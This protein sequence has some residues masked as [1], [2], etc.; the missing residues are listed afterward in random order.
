MENPF[1]YY[2]IVTGED[3]ADRKAEL[4]ELSLAV[5]SQA[6]VFLVSPR[7]YGKSSLLTALLTRFDRDSVMTVYFDVSK[8]TSLRAL[9]EKFASETIKA[10]ETGLDKVA[11]TVKDF[12]PRLRP[13]ITIEQDGTP[14]LK[15]DVAHGES[16]LLENAE[17]ILDAPEVFAKKRRKPFLVVLDEFQ[18]VL[19]FNGLDLEKLLRAVIQ[20][21]EHVSYVFAGSRPSLLLD[22]V[23]NRSRPFYKMGKIFNLGKIPRAEF[24]PFLL[25]RFRKTGYKID[26]PLMDHILDLAEDYPYNAQYLCHELWNHARDKKHITVVEVDFCLNKILGSLTAVYAQIL[27]GLTLKQRNLLRAIAVAGGYNI[28]S[29]HFRKSHD[30]GAAST[31][32]MSGKLLRNKELLEVES[33][34]YYIPDV[35][36]K[37]WIKRNLN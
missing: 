8:V 22:M 14:A 11:K 33:G 3:F 17:E 29:E 24:K 7:R 32:A 36:L 10:S 28:H 26:G 12:F 27:E 20:R 4:E 25:A 13:K 19:S 2:R 18:E 6:R 31:V 30:L 9:L 34:R 16:D 15:L 1:Y 23:S 35:F 5:T 21:H 37:E